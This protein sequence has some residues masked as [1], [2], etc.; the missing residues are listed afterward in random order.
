MWAD[1]S[2]VRCTRLARTGRLAALLE[3]PITVPGRS[4][5]DLMFN[6]DDS[7]DL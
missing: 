2:R 4:T 6:D 1:C 3:L 5:P 7:S